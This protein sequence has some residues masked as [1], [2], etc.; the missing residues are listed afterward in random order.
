[1]L[2]QK[3]GK[4]FYRY[5]PDAAGKPRKLPAPDTH[6]LLAQL[7]DGTREF[8]ADDIVQRMML[9][10]LIEAAHALEEG[11]VQ[12]P[13][14]LDMALTLGLGFPAYLGGPLKYADWLGMPAVV[15]RAESF[16]SLGEAY[17]PTARMREMAASGARYY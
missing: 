9:P 6:D 11:I 1:M 2:G 13:A 10:M 16:A 15:E 3:T 5:E 17:R 7:Q 4:G 14:E 8:S 12:S